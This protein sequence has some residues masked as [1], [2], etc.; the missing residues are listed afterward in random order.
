MKDT[1]QPGTNKQEGTSV[2]SIVG[3]RY[4][5][6][7]STVSPVLAPEQCVCPKIGALY[8]KAQGTCLLSEVM[9][10][11]KEVGKSS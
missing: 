9:G 8:L 11:M 6:T 4:C 5:Q 3:W 7:L 10:T 2:E 1:P